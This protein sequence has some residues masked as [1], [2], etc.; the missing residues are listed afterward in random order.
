VT[1]EP[2]T[3]RSKFT[4]DRQ[5]TILE[6]FACGASVETAA[7]LARI[8]PLTLFRWLA[9]GRDE[10]EDSRYGKF[11]LDCQ[12][13][14]AEPKERALKI[15]ADALPDYPMLAWKY[16]ERMEKGYAPPQ[17]GTV[18]A[19]GP[20]VIQLSFDNGRPLALAPTTEI[21][22]GEITDEGEDV[23]PTSITAA[24]AD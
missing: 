11:Y 19:G 1:Y 24:A 2:K 22:V 10:P 7:G 9:K 6:A 20:T 17:I 3:G 21:E 4:V 23:E 12:Q 13:A 5:K 16:L 18:Q 15:V 14:R 8:T